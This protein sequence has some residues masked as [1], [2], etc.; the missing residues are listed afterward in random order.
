VT[1][2]DLLL[3]ALHHTDGPALR[4]LPEEAAVLLEGLDAPP[5]LAA[6]LRAVHDVTHQLVDWMWRR[7]PAPRFDREAVLFGAAT[8]DIGK[9]VYVAELTG[10]GSRPE[11]AG[12]GLL[13]AHGF[14]PRLAR[15]AATHAAWADAGPGTGIE[16]L[17]VSVADKIWKNKRVP[18]LEDLL[19]T[20]LTRASGRAAWEEFM[21]LGDE[22][23]R[24]GRGADA[25]PAFQTSYPVGRIRT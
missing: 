21:M 10:P 22:L 19:V 25:R 20:R 16:D 4:P 3:R 9:T 8:H 17:L 18:D 15:F 2:A 7:H 23:A 11:E 6:H 5:R 14:E 12:R 1:T 24:I 13:L